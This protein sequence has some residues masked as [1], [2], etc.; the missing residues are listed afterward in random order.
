MNSAALLPA[1][2]GRAPGW[3]A[4]AAGSRLPY[5][6]PTSDCRDAVIAVGYAGS[7]VCSG[8][9]GTSLL[10]TLQ[11]AGILAADNSSGRCVPTLGGR[12]LSLFGVTSVAPFSEANTGGTP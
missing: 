6:G 4:R 3:R 7:L 9:A 2:L 1:A 10:S 11:S 5:S 12:R 8:V